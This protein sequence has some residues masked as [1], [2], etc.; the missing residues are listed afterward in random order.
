VALNWRNMRPNAQ[1]NLQLK[2]IPNL[3][4]QASS[5]LPVYRPSTGLPAQHASAPPVYGSNPAAPLQGIATPALYGPGATSVVQRTGAPPIDRH[6]V[7]LP[8]QGMKAPA[9]YRPTP[10][11][12]V[13][14]MAAPPVYKPIVAAAVQRTAAPPIDR[15][16]V[17]LTVQRRTALLLYKPS[18]ASS[19]GIKNVPLGPKTGGFSRFTQA[20]AAPS[21]S[22][23]TELVCFHRR[24]LDQ[25]VR[26]AQIHG[27]IR[28]TQY[29]LPI[30]QLVIP[31]CSRDWRNGSQTQRTSRPRQ[32]L[33]SS[34]SRDIQIS[35]LRFKW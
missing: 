4:A 18:P 1:R 2:P 30:P 34:L 35:T 23:Q 21:L 24:R 11:A 7:G 28:G 10:A 20:M 14:R 29:P 8:V 9:V 27:P 25:W 32:D 5:A 12:P 22:A 15:P 33:S 6:S 13:Q 26:P 17:R 31:F 16:E 19:A 3:P